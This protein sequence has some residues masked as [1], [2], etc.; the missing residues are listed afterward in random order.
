MIT[1]SVF[2]LIR[3]NERHVLEDIPHLKCHVQ[4]IEF[5]SLTYYGVFD[6]KF[7]FIFHM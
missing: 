3:R 2:F 1:I 5:D 4:V 7:F 6:F